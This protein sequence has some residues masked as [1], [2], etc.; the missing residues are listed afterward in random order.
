MNEGSSC[1]WRPTCSTCQA[2]I[3]RTTWEPDGPRRRRHSRFVR[4]RGG[5]C[6]GGGEGELVDSN[7][8][9]PRWLTK[10]RWT[11]DFPWIPRIREFLVFS[12]SCVIGGLIMRRWKALQES[13][14]TST[15]SAG[16]WWNGCAGFVD[17]WICVDCLDCVEV[18]SV[19]CHLPSAIWRLP[20]AICPS[21]TCPSAHQLCASAAAV[22]HDLRIP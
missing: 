6:T 16:E 13:R 20:S 2:M 19:I 15:W 21:A 12:P 10:W 17:Y 8:P 14:R 1:H 3:G 7:Y 9:L 4:R 11:M 22:R 18:P 5:V